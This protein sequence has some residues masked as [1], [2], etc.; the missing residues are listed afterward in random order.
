MYLTVTSLTFYFELCDKLHVSLAPPCNCNYLLL[1]QVS[2][3]KQHGPC[4][5][6]RERERERENNNSHVLVWTETY[7]IWFGLKLTP[8]FTHHGAFSVKACPVS[9]TDSYKMQFDS[10]QNMSYFYASWHFS[11]CGTRYVYILDD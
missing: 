7:S 1:M 2:H 5:S 11:S 6:M 8:N 3:W 10:V 9:L 4:Q